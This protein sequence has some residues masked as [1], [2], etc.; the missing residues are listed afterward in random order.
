MHESTSKIHGVML[1]RMGWYIKGVLDD[2]LF[3][4]LKVH[5]LS[6]VMST[7]ISLATTTRT[8]H[9]IQV[10]YAHVQDLSLPSEMSQSSGNQNFK[11][12]LDYQQWKQNT[13]R[14]QQQ[15]KVWYMMHALLFEFNKHFTLT[16][17]SRVSTIS[18]VFEDNRACQI[19]ASTDPPRLTPRSK[20][21]AIKY[22]CFRTHLSPDSIVLKAIPSSLQKGD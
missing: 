22:H 16:I 6:L 1:K 11:R 21:L 9:L 17:S 10:Q 3:I 4:I 20:S 2:G 19:L 7:P 14:C 18:T 5:S 12:K 15:C 13:L 8:I